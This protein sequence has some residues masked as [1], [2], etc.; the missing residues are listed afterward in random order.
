[1]ISPQQ[2]LLKNEDLIKLVMEHEY[3]PQN[4][5]GNFMEVKGALQQIDGVK[6]ETGSCTTCVKEI[7][8]MANIHLQAY[9]K[10][11]VTA[12]VIEPVFHKFPKH[13]K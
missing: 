12:T 9:K 8:T 1:M 7:I 10:T 3:M 5:Q 4:Q 13:K 2:I 11:I 6:R